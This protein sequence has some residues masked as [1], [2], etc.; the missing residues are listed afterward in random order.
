MCGKWGRLEWV[1]R[2]WSSLVLVRVDGAIV[3]VGVV[4]A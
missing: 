1:G 3:V 4:V 2:G